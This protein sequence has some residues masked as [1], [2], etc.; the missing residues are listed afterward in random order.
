MWP[1]SIPG[2]VYKKSLHVTYHLDLKPLQHFK[3]TWGVDCEQTGSGIPF[4]NWTR[5]LSTV[6]YFSPIK[7][8]N[9]FFPLETLFF[10]QMDTPLPNIHHPQSFL[11]V[12]VMFALNGRAPC[13]LGADSIYNPILE[14]NQS[15]MRKRFGGFYS[16]IEPIPC[17]VFSENFP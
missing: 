16:G 3:T 6:F 1:D 9:H 13:G 5:W 17:D 12:F 2:W 15:T 11:L 8:L 10:G 4:W 14:W 7:E